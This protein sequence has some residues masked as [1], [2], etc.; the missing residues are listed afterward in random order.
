MLRAEGTDVLAF[1]CMKNCLQGQKKI[2]FLLQ[3]NNATFNL[4]RECIMKTPKP[5]LGNWLL[6][7]MLLRY[8]QVFGL[9][10][11]WLK[12]TCRRFPVQNQCLIDGVR[13]CLPLRGSSG[14]LPDSL[15]IAN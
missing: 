13:S 4:G 7:A 9:T 15:F 8:R 3:L 14:L 5:P 12:P 10:G 2:R 6:L 1:M 11:I